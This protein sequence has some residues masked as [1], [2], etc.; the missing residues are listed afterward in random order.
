M[1]DTA[2]GLLRQAG[3]RPGRSKDLSDVRSLLASRGY[4]IGKPVELFLREFTGITIDFVR[5]GRPD[6]IWFDAERASALADSEWVA[7]Y[8]QRTKTSL[9]PIGFSY[10]EHL[11]LMISGEGGFYGAY[12]DFLCALG[13]EAREMIER[14]VNHER[15]PLIQ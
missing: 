3:W 4:S 12:D 5:N 7:H 9:V 1:Q 10:H 8:G 14:L 2:E 15:G 11:M 6:S 13:S